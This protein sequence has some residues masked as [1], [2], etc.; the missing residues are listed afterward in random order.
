MVR[1]LLFWLA[2]CI[3]YPAAVIATL[4]LNPV[5]AA[6]P[7]PISVEIT[8]HLGDQQSFVDGDVISFLLSLDR[9]AYIYLYYQD[10]SANIFQIFPNRRSG[11]HFYRKGFFMPLPPSQ[12]NFQF[13]IQPPFGDEKLSVFATDNADVRLEAR[14]LNNGLSMVTATIREIEASF[15]QQSDLQFGSA[16]LII[17][18]QPR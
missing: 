17:K 18:S 2:T 3:L 14:P 9:D 7:E 6:E 15:R 8:T 16:S 1:A 5:A 12:I 10:A 13:K 4:V 11:N